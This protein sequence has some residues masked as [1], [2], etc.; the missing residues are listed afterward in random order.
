M[1]YAIGITTYLNLNNGGLLD[2]FILVILFFI[3]PLLLV[4][5]I[6]KFS[7]TKWDEILK[8]QSVKHEF[9][10]NTEIIRD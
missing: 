8:T 9:K 1:D 3:I 4:S 5:I 7:L 2:S 6:I 10:W